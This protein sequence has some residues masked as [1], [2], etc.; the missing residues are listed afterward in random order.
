VFP[1]L[2]IVRSWAEGQRYEPATIATFPDVA[3][4]SDGPILVS[5]VDA[6]SNRAKFRP[7]R[8]LKVIPDPQDRRVMTI[9]T[10]PGVW[11]SSFRPCPTPA[12]VLA[13]RKLPFPFKRPFPNPRYEGNDA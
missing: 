12:P 4:F 8:V 2:A 1:S 9:P 13:V 10:M 7:K 6:A 5:N 3:D 11:F